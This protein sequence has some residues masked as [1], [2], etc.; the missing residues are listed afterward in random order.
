MTARILGAVGQHE[1]EHKSERVRAAKAVDA[2]NGK[3]NTGIRCFGYAPDGMT[4]WEE[5]ADEIRRV[6]DAIMRGVS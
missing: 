3:H 2:K 1:S 6:A 5:E 4:I